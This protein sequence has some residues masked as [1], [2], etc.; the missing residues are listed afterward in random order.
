MVALWVARWGLLV[1]GVVAVAVAFAEEVRARRA[2]R[3]NGP[4][5]TDSDVTPALVE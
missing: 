5:A 2:A 3:R 4:E 1:A